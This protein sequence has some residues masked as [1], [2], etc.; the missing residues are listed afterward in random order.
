MPQLEQR[1]P[2]GYSSIADIIK[3]RK[4]MAGGAEG[5]LKASNA[6]ANAMHRS[7]TIAHMRLSRGLS[8]QALSKLCGLAQSHISRI[9]TG[10]DV[11]CSSLAQLARG[12]DAPISEVQAA[13]QITLELNP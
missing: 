13:Y 5:L 10:E 7:G 3:R 1:L 8:Q 12:L 9:E 2:E 4:A 6:L 11:L